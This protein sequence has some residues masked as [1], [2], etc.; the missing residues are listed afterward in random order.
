MPF[1]WVAAGSAIL[2]AVT[3]MSAAD[4]QA[5][6]EKSAQQQAQAQYDQTRADQA[7]FRDASTNALAQITAGTAPGGQFTKTFSGLGDLSDDPGYQFRMDQG[8]KG[9]DAG[10]AA[11][12]GALSGAT[13]KAEQRYG[14][15]YASGEYNNAFN[16]Y[17]TQQTNAFNRLASA[18]GIGQ[19]A[20]NQTQAAGQAATTAGIDATIGGANA[21]AAGLVGVSNAVSNGSNSLANWY[22]QRQYLSGMGSSNYQTPMQFQDG[23]NYYGG[24]GTTLYGDGYGLG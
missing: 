14:Q 15:D 13:I 5:D 23:T 9:V 19:T 18:A 3:S 16:R 1:G 12:G 24:S 11:R 10:A 6:A 2:G 22:Q 7:P 17:T 4:K 20:A 8:M 21:Q